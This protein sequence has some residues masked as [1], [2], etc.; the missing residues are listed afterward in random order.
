MFESLILRFGVA[1]VTAAIGVLL[2]AIFLSGLFGFAKFK[3]WYYHH[4]D[5]K[6]VAQ[7]DQARAERDIARKD[8]AQVERSSTISASTVAAQDQHA[9]A[10]RAAT[11]QSSEVIRERIRQVPVVVPVPDDPVVRA[12]ANEAVAR[13]QAAADRV[14]GAPPG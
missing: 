5:V 6:H 13:A 14:R 11:T 3:A 4:Q 7:R 1:K 9:G 12:A 8:E 10:Q 2:I